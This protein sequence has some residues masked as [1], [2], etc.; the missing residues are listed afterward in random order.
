MVS[1]FCFSS[2]NDTYP[3]IRIYFVNSFHALTHLFR[4]CG[5]TK[6]VQMMISYVITKEHSL[7]SFGVSIRLWFELGSQI[8]GNILGN[9]EDSTMVWQDEPTV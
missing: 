7:S 1:L 4:V 9:R 6:I 5:Q 8:D 2:G 3:M